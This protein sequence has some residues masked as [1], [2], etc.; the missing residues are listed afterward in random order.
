MPLYTYVNSM[1]WQAKPPCS[2]DT[3]ALAQASPSN[4]RALQ[5]GGRL[6]THLNQIGWRHTVAIGIARCC[7]AAAAVAVA[8][9]RREP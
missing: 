5:D 8:I 2:A 4:Q 6:S 3:Q 7:T 9:F 1:R